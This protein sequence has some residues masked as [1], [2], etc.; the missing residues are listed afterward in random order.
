MKKTY[1]EPRVRIL[2]V[3]NATPLNTSIDGGVSSNSDFYYG[4]GSDGDTEGRAKTNSV[5]DDNWE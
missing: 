4:G 2:S 3:N 1:Q 5:W